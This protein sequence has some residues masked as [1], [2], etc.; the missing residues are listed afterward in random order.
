MRMHYGRGQLDIDVINWTYAR[1]LPH[2][3]NGVT[4]TLAVFAFAFAFGLGL[5]F[6]FVGVSAG[7]ADLLW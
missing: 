7:A 5:G 3:S 4:A 1:G 2:S 6:G